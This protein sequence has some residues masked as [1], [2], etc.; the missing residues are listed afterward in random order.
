MQILVAIILC[1]S[2]IYILTLL[3][4]VQIRRNAKFSQPLQ[5]KKTRARKPSILRSRVLAI[6]E[7]D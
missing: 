2:L 1:D 4:G 5:C 3:R 7:V 6:L